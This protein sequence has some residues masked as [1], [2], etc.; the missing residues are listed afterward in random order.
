MPSSMA[1]IFLLL[2]VPCL[3]AASQVALFESRKELFLSAPSFAVVGASGDESKYGTIVFKTLLDQG[4][5]VVPIN[6]FSPTSQ[7]IP[8]LH[9]L[10]DLP[11]PSR[12]SISIVTQPSVT[13]EILKQAEDLGIFAVWLQ[14]GAEDAAVLEFMGN[15]TRTGHYVFSAGGVGRRGVPPNTNTGSPCGSDGKPDLIS[16]LRR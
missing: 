8:C 13:L 14:P 4:V 7:G 11:D 1:A 2:L 16:T 12:T 5:D 3:S 9:S 10:A 6:P 15:S